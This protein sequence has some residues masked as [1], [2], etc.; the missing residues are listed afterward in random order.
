MLKLIM[1][2]ERNLTEESI[3][4]FVKGLR[5]KKTEAEYF[6]ILVRFNQTKSEPTGITPL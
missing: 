1:E 2:G 6:R 3:E 4:K 5:L